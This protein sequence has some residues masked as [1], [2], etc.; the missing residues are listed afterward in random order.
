ML[1]KVAAIDRVVQV[2][3]FAVALLAGH[4]VDAVDPALAH[5]RCAS[6]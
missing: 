4:R 6:V 2:Q 5:K 1:Q 3:P